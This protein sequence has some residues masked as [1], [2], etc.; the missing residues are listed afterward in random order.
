[1]CYGSLPPK[2][3]PKERLL[4]A[5]DAGL[6]G[7]EIPTF[8]TQ[9]QTEEIAALAEEAGIELDKLA[10]LCVFLNIPRCHQ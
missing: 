5:K 1:M 2:L 9:E 10:Y 8:E 3:S 4:L 6:D 7:V